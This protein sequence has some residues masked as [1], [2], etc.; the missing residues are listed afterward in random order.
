MF[1]D[2]PWIA[3]TSSCFRELLLAF[4]NIFKSQEGECTFQLAEFSA[5]SLFGFN[6]QN[7]R[8]VIPNS[9]FKRHLY[10][11]VGPM[12]CIPKCY[13]KFFFVNIN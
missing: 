8:E 6:F 9:G 7:I 13:L 2:K 3:L 10:F 1:C 12:D 4:K 11:S 5:M